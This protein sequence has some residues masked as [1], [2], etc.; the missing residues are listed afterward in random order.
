MA[1]QKLF[2]AG[3]KKIGLLRVETENASGVNADEYKSY[4]KVLYLPKGYRLKVDFKVYNTE[5]P[6]LFFISPNQFLQ[7]EVLEQRPAILFFTIVIF[8]ASRI[9]DDESGL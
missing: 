9:H 6:S 7:I 8:I 4:I 3:L 1:Q 5:G 2:D